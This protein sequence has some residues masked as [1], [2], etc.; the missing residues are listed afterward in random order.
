MAEFH[1][2]M[3]ISCNFSNSTNSDISHIF[4]KGG[5]SSSVSRTPS[6]DSRGVQTDEIFEKTAAVAALYKKS[7]ITQSSSPSADGAK[8]RWVRAFHFG[9]FC[10]FYRLIF[11]NWYVCVCVSLQKSAVCLFRAIK[12]SNLSIIQRI[13]WTTKSAKFTKRRENRS[14]NNRREC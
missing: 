11:G 14:T 5:K 6:V 13:G 8:F 3:F 2:L 10:W 1:T 7:L 12:Y 9:A 4:R